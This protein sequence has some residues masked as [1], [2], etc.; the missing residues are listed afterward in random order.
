MTKV[1]K[2]ISI[3]KR[4]VKLAEQQAKN[5]VDTYLKQL[6]NEEKRT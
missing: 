3:D 6:L 2:S 5:L 4:I 1:N